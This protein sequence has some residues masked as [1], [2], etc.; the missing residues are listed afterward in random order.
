MSDLCRNHAAAERSDLI[1]TNKP[2]APIRKCLGLEA[3]L[4]RKRQKAEQRD[5]REHYGEEASNS[6][7]IDSLIVYSR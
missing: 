3:S 2:L 7:D 1:P 5:H 6:P 4:R